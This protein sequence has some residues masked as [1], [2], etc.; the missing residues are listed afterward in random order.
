MQN[1]I[2][3]T[4]CGDISMSKYMT[5]AVGPDLVTNQSAFDLII[6][7][8]IEY[9]VDGFYFLAQSPR[10][11]YMAQSEEYIYALLDAFLSLSR[12]GK[13]ILLGYANQQ[14]IV[15]AAAGVDLI[16]SG[17]FRNVRA[18]DPNIFSQQ[19]PGNQ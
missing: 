9:P 5:V 19:E 12:S 8:M 16:A 10:N 4:D 2:A 3:N 7:E 17:N 6:D 13:E 18:F 15:Y 1:H 14:S 11:Q